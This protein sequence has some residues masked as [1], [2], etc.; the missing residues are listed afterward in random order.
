MLSPNVNWHKN[1]QFSWKS[2]AFLL[3]KSEMVTS[4][5]EIQ[6]SVWSLGR[7]IQKRENSTCFYKVEKQKVL[8]IIWVKIPGSAA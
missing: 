8:V 1:R 2:I 3:S 6:K 4:Q 7:G 5:E